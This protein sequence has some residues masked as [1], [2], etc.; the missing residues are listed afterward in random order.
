VRAQ[1]LER[2]F[3]V[4]ARD[5]GLSCRFLPTQLRASQGASFEPPVISFG[6]WNLPERSKQPDSAQLLRKYIWGSRGYF[7]SDSRKPF[8]PITEE[9]RMIISRHISL[10]SAG[11][12]TR[13]HSHNPGGA[14][15]PRG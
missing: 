12:I 5:K 1:G 9:I 3:G 11:G 4:A 6:R 2:G 13:A 14:Q 15:T 7:G 8:R 10:D